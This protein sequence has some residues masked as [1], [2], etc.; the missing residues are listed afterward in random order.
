MSKFRL[1]NGVPTKWFELTDSMKDAENWKAK[2]ILGNS[3]GSDDNPKGYLN[4]IGYVM[5]SLVDNTII[6]ISRAD[7]HQRGFE[8]LDDF[9]AS[10]YNINSDD[11]FPV[12][13]FGNNYP[14]NK[15]ELQKLKITLS[16]AEYY[17]LDLTNIMVY[18]GYINH[19]FADDQY[20]SAQEF[21]SGNITKNKNKKT[22]TPLAKQWINSLQK[23]SKAFEK[24]SIQQDEKYLKAI[25]NAVN[26]LSKI[27]VNIGITDYLNGKIISAKD[28][29]EMKWAIYDYRFG[30]SNFST[31]EQ[32]F[33]GFN[34]FR[35]RWHNW[36]RKN[37]DNNRVKV[38]LGDV[39]KVIEMMSAI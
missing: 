2:T 37:A 25:E 20:I 3:I 28:N 30:N 39:E 7:E 9:Y 31:F 33:F 1:P 21:L 13:C 29:E 4:K 26:E 34:G 32:K 11:Y 19:S 38:E 22:I 12:W 5:I 23:L 10:K 24:E 8:L 17:G 15:D 6:P 36:L 27:A 16:K 14:Y 18:M 35:N